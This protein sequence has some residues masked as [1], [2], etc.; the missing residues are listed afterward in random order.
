MT[1]HVTDISRWGLYSMLVAC[2]GL[3]RDNCTC[4]RCWYMGM[5]HQ[6]HNLHVTGVSTLCW[7]YL[8]QCMLWDWHNI[9]DCDCQH[10]I[11]YC[12]I[13]RSRFGISDMDRF[14]WVK[15]RLFLLRFMVIWL[16]NLPFPNGL[17]ATSVWIFNLNSE[18][19]TCTPNLDLQ[20]WTHISVDMVKT[21]SFITALSSVIYCFIM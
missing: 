3:V 11:S 21:G 1:A 8:Y 2:F 20:L 9:S 14:C 17:L 15:F 16:E 12:R 6:L 5:V 13:Y 19:E 18:L 7:Y 4:Y 10:E